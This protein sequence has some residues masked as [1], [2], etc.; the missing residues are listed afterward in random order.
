MDRSNHQAKAEP[1]ANDFRASAPNFSP[2]FPVFLS[3][4]AVLPCRRSAIPEA[5]VLYT[6][7]CFFVILVTGFSST[8]QHFA[9]NG[10][11]KGCKRG[12]SLW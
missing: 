1:N 12:G 8:V 6:L 10:R 7:F 3:Y 4:S 11:L 5:Y 2:R 9:C